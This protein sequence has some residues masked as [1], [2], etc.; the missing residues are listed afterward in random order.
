VPVPFGA[1]RGNGVG[2][3]DGGAGG[4]GASQNAPCYVL[5]LS[6]DGTS[7][8]PLPAVPL[9]KGTSDATLTGVSCTTTRYC[10]ALGE[11]DGDTAA[12]G[13]AGALTIIETWNG[14][15]WTLHTAAVPDGHTTAAELTTVSCATSEFCVLAGEATS[16]T[17]S[18]AAIGLY[19]ASWQLGQHYRVH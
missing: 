12:F 13:D 4:P 9:P 5:A 17:S 15:K 7:L 8:K 11:A 3:G 18:S 6:Y 1:H 19:V 2:H 10:V 16:F 14:T